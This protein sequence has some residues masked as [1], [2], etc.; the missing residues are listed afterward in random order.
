MKKW[1]VTL[2]G[3]AALMTACAQPDP[4]DRIDDRANVPT[5]PADDIEIEDND[6]PVSLFQEGTFIEAIGG[7]LDGAVGPVTGLNNDAESLSFY[8]DGFY[9]Q[10]NVIAQN[11]NGAAMAIVSLNGSVRALNV[12]GEDGPVRTCQDDF[13]DPDSEVNNGGVFASVTGCAGSSMNSWEY[14]APSDCTD[15]EIGE[16]GPEAP[17][18]TVATMS[19]LAHWSGEY[20]G[21]ER[22][23][24]ATI[25]LTE[26]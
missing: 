11:G 2:A 16:P 24:K 23:V 17:E 3:S 26:R 7:R 5:S 4:V 25:H 1:M 22:T 19:V 18:G 12:D 9:T 14:D 13:Y 8:D 10:A 21:V 6:G 15:V 20:G